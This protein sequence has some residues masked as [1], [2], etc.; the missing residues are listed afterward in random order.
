MST[1]ELALAKSPIINHKC[2]FNIAHYA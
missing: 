1:L 2:K